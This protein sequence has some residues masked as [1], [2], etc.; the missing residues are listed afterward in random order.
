MNIYKYVHVLNE[1]E[2]LDEYIYMYE[3]KY[4]APNI[5]SKI[6]ETILESQELKLKKACWPFIK[7]VF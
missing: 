7:G 3:V 5:T 1:I 2:D 6:Y 4:H